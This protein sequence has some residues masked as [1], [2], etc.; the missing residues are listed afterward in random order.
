MV[1]SSL[2]RPLEVCKSVWPL[3]EAIFYIRL[4]ATVD[5][6][7]LPAIILHNIIKAQHAGIGFPLRLTDKGLVT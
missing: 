3:T 1:M 4:L 6:P 7:S 5:F 2:V